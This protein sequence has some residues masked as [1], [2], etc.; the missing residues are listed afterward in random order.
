MLRAKRGFLIEA[1]PPPRGGARRSAQQH[2]HFVGMHDVEIAAQ[3]FAG[4]IGIDMA[5][6]EQ[7]HAVAQII[8]LRGQPRHFHPAFGQKPLVFTP[9]EQ[10]A[11]PGDGEARHDEQTD[12]RDTLGQAFTRELRFGA[13]LFHKRIESQLMP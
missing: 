3:K 13:V 1:Y 8:A 11:W 4:E 10:A 2:D 7:G 12:Q 5:R 9:G 6:I